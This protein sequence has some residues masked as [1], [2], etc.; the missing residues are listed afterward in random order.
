MISDS[1][2]ASW[3]QGESGEKVGR[4]WLGFHTKRGYGGGFIVPLAGGGGGDEILAKTM[5]NFICYNC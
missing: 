3:I 5:E 1:D 2:S 4:T